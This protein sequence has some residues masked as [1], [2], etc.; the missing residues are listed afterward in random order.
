MSFPPPLPAATPTRISTSTI[1]ATGGLTLRDFSLLTKGSFK[2]MRNW[3]QEGKGVFRK[4]AGSTKEF[5]VTTGTDA[6]AQ[7]TFAVQANDDL[8]YI[9]YGQSIATWVES[10]DTVAVIANATFTADVTD[11]ILYGQYLFILSGNAGD[12]LQ[13]IDTTGAPSTVVATVG[14]PKGERITVVS[15]NRLAIGNTD[16][17]IS[18][19]HVSRV[20]QLTGVPFSLA[21]DW[22][23][24]TTPTSPFKITFKDAK[25]FVGFGRIGS[26]IIAL[27]D[28]GKLG[29]R[30]TQISDGSQL[31][32]NT[33]IDFENVDFGATRG[34]TSTSKGVFYVN[35]FG[36]YQMA[37]G[38]FTDVPFSTQ[39][40][41]ISEP[42]GLD[43]TSNFNFTNS[44]LISDQSRELL[45]ITAAENGTVNNVVLVYNF[46]K[47]LV[48]WSTMDKNIARFRKVGSDIY[49]GSSTDT[50]LWKL[51]Y[52]IATDD[53]Q[54]M[55][56][57]LDI[58]PVMSG[59][60]QLS[61]LRRFSIGGE[62]SVDSTT[63]ISFDTWNRNWQSQ[64]LSRTITWTASGVV[65]S[66]EGIGATEVGGAIG[67]ETATGESLNPRFD[68]YRVPSGDSLRYRVK[69][70]NQD[71]YLMKLNQ[72]TLFVEPRGVVTNNS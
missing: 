52:S 30:I 67:G 9:G 65:S 71:G 16:T 26:Q 50:S 57:E 29:F 33:P 3:F 64:T 8:W 5:E 58:E 12:I 46:N 41:K 59:I 13:Y 66:I 10:T 7:V 55:Y 19:V 43:F 28:E 21:A 25:E 40:T 20:D 51:D 6:G 36:V 34:V 1:S 27:H 68:D 24:G 54:D 23:V 18:E 49:F 14:S 61:R 32:L 60:N 42:L 22:T 17:A 44:D 2:T 56:C 63:S 72:I 47:D 39:E 48:G 4:S 35:D 37:S 45:F 15:S 11:A 31:V 53:T 70:I 69:I 38:G 62:L